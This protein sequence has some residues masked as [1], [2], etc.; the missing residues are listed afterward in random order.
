MAAATQQTETIET[1]HEDLIV[2]AR[3]RAWR[4]ARGA[5]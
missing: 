1:L 5:R 3:A 2:R 4:M